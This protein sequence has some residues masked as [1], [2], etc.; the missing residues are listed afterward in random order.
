MN[1]GKPGRVAGFKC[2][3]ESRRRTVSSSGFTLLELMVVIA[4]IAI[5]AAFTIARITEMRIAAN[6]A[7]TIVSLREISAAQIAY[8]ERNIDEFGRKS[9]AVTLKELADER[10][11]DE[12]VGTGRKAGYIIR[13]EPFG[14]NSQ[15]A[16]QATAEPEVPDKS[17]E[18]YFYVDHSTVIRWSRS[19][20]ANASSTPLEGQRVSP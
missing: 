3:P 11:I 8:Y 17:G 18:R 19:G 20:P 4:L 6:E 13:I 10:L 2:S 1:S 14:V 15:Y 9:Y 5:I 7:S 16:W 12:K